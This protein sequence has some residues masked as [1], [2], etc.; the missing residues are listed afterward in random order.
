MRADLIG[1]YDRQTEVEYRGEHYLV[2][3]NGA[4]LRLGRSNGRKR[5]LDN[6]WTFGSPERSSNYL[7]VGTHVVHRIVAFAFHE[8]PSD[9][10]VVDHIDTNRR[11]NR[12]E[13]LRWV[14]RLENVMA[15]PITD[16][17]SVV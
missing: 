7:C 3:D 11:N 17:K 15:N 1:R 13:N 2:R 10:H 4:V 5:K 8:Q 9:K 14:T 6:E 12:A 16:R